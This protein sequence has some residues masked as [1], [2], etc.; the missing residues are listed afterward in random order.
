MNLLV[1]A[2][3]SWLLAQ[4]LPERRD[5][6]LIVLAGSIPDLDALSLLGGPEAYFAYH[7]AVLHG[8]VGALGVAAACTCLAR[9][10][11]AVCMLSLMA[12]HLHLVC[13]LA[14]SGPRWPVLY[15][16]PW[17]R[18]RW[19]WLGQWD[20]NAWENHLIAALT[21]LACAGCAIPL[22]RTAIEV[23][24]PAAD[25]WVTDRLRRLIPAFADRCGR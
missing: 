11:V 15:F 4:G 12:F 2:G 10:R 17:D 7:H 20:L 5:R 22:R 13:D 24:C 6:R 3:L 9:S 25:R 21:F 1:H 14:G 8:L 16:W 23:L 19:Y 18:H